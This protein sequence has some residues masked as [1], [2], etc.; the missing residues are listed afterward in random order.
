MPLAWG[1]APIIAELFPGLWSYFGDTATDSDS[2]FGATGGVGYCYP[3]N[4]PNTSAFFAEARRLYATYMPQDHSWAD[5]WEGA[6]PSAGGGSVAPPSPPNPCDKLYDAFRAGSRISGFSQQPTTARNAKE[7]SFVLNEWLSDGTPVFLPPG[8]LW[9]SQE[10]QF[11]DRALDLDAEADCIEGW[12]RAAAGNNTQ[13]PLF[14]LAYGVDRYI[15][16]A[17]RMQRRLGAGFE[18]IGAQDLAALGRA[19]APGRE[20]SE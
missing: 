13:R 4:L 8:S 18:I 11:C 17:L 3:W 14:V 6:C 9:Y 10:K 1:V 20:S 5:V 7:P 12:I 16:V 15:D 19:A 2:F